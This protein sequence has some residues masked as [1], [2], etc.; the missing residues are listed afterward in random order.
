MRKK[1]IRWLAGLILLLFGLVMCVWALIPDKQITKTTKILTPVYDNKSEEERALILI[2]PPKLKTGCV[3]NIQIELYPEQNN[4]NANGKGDENGNDVIQ[5]HILIE[6]R[7]EFPEVQIFPNVTMRQPILEET[8]LGF[9]W[10]IK[11]VHSGNFKGTIWLYT[12]FQDDESD[13]EQRSVL[14]TQRIELDAINFMRLNCVTAKIV[15]V[16][17]MGIG[18]LMLIDW[19]ALTIEKLIYRIKV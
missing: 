12:I 4:N 3:G 8:P 11:P 19:I 2:F 15:S 5:N 1:K 14:A 13:H 7:L 17:V 9:V 18:L 10:N 16:F 6:T